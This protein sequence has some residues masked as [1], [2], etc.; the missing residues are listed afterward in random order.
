MERG[1][2][3][4]INLPKVLLDIVPY[5]EFRNKLLTSTLNSIDEEVIGISD[6]TAEILKIHPAIRDIQKQRIIRES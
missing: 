5:L 3:A 6:E 4:F 2:K 1:K